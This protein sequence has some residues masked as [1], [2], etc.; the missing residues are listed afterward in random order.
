MEFETGM[1]IGQERLS[2]P[3]LIKIRAAYSLMK[4]LTYYFTSTKRV[5]QRHTEV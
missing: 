3:F 2:G 1:K 4:E 5:A